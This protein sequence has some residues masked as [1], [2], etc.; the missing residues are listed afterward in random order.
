MTTVGVCE[1]RNNTAELLERARC[2]ED[3]I[4]TKRGIPFARLVPFDPHSRPYL[5]KSDLLKFPLADPGL[6]D[7][8]AE[9][10]GETADD[11]GA[12]T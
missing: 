6:R 9:L 1:L 11:P 3:I 10:A 8:L 12:T 5:T 7:D 4:I 2:G